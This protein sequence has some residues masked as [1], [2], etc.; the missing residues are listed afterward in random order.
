MLNGFRQVSPAL[1]CDSWKLDTTLVI[2]IHIYH[3]LEQLFKV[4]ILSNIHTCS[5][6][7]TLMVR[8]ISWQCSLSHLFDSDIFLLGFYYSWITAYFEWFISYK[9]L[10]EQLTVSHS[11]N[12]TRK[13]K[14][15]VFSEKSIWKT[16]LY[17]LLIVSHLWQTIIHTGTAVYPS[18]SV[19][20]YFTLS[21]DR[22]VAD[23]LKIACNCFTMLCFHRCIANF[24]SLNFL[25]ETHALEVKVNRWMKSYS[26]LIVS[27]I[28]FL[29]VCNDMKL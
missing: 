2:T 23:C 26:A 28:F 12:C 29:L 25:T 16:I 15:I 14:T 11:F 1:P 27:C 6:N 22:I 24:I 13:S 3:N 20:F 4:R 8:M 19:I 18:Q 17:L 10:Y 9:I 7:T 21:T 5:L